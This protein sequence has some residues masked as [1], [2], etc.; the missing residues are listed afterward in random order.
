MEH[1][2]HLL[3]AQ[4]GHDLRFRTGGFRD[5]D[6]HRKSLRIDAHLLGPQAID[7]GVPLRHLERGQRQFRAIGHEQNVAA[8]SGEPSLDHVHRG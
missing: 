3:P 4:P 7:D 8:R 1:E 6:F 5:H 2:C